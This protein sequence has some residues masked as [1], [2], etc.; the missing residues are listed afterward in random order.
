ME[1]HKSLPEDMRKF[2]KALNTLKGLRIYHLTLSDRIEA[3]QYMEKFSLKCDDALAVQ[4]IK[5]FKIKQ[6]V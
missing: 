4:A 3:P 5:R 2:I 6:I 1:H